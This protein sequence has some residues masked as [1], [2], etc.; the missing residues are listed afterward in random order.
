MPEI[1]EAAMADEPNTPP[2][3]TPPADPP[4]PPADQPLGEAG[5]RALVAE[6]E[7]RKAAEAINAQSQ[8]A[9]A[10]KASE[11]ARQKAERE[12]AEAKTRLETLQRAQESETERL[13]REAEEGRNL[14]QQGT[15]AV[16]EARLLTSLT[17]RGLAGPN[18][19]AAVRLLDGVEF[20]AANNPTNLDARLTAARQLY[21]EAPFSAGATPPGTPSPVPD[22]PHGGQPANG[23]ELPPG[24]VMHPAG[25]PIPAAHYNA[26]QV[27]PPQPSHQGA[28]PG[29][30]ALTEDQQFDEYMKRSFPH[31][32]QEPSTP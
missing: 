22:V 10:L 24:M 6:R 9:R 5:Q 7:A 32:F 19:L 18:A 4:Q 23:A 29:Q 13:K 15:A 25:F 31:L 17:G 11:D 30:P 14:A 26:R 12:A 2:V 20:D 1:G 8:D 3:N 16:R 28:R 21:G 27:G